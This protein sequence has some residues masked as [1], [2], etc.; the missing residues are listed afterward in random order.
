V[1]NAHY[2]NNHRFEQELLAGDRDAV[3]RALYTLA[4]HVFAM[5]VLRFPPGLDADDVVQLATLEALRRLEKWEPGRSS[6]FSYATG[7]IKFTIMAEIK[8]ERVWAQRHT[9]L[10][11]SIDEEAA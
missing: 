6:A 11:L 8:K 1:A 2:F 3:A 7:S 9:P 10:L 5:Q 4:Q